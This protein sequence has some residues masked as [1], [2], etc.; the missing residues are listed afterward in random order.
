M[1]FGFRQ[2]NAIKAIFRDNLPNYVVEFHKDISGNYRYLK[3]KKEM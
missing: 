1:E 2:K 3:A